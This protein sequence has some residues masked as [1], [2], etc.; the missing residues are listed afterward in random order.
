MFVNLLA[1]K[2]FF[3]AKSLVSK[4]LKRYLYCQLQRFCPAHLHFSNTPLKVNKC[5]NTENEIKPILSRHIVFVA[6]ERKRPFQEVLIH[7]ASDL[8]LS[9]RSC[10]QNPCL[11]YAQFPQ[12]TTESIFHSN[13]VS[14]VTCS[15][16]KLRRLIWADSLGLGTGMG[17]GL[18]T[19][20]ATRKMSIH[21]VLSVTFT[22]KIT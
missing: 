3:S 20:S 10:S 4:V 11:T 21:V 12:C 14:D 2:R 22:F 18:A 8:L 1:A 17:A 9:F 5:T 13:T 7:R 16:R 6:R 19:W 15:T